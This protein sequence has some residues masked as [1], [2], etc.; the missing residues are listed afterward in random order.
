M[1]PRVAPIDHC[2]HSPATPTVD[3]FPPRELHRYALGT[4]AE[5]AASPSSRGESDD[6]GRQLQRCFPELPRMKLLGRSE[7]WWQISE[8]SM[9]TLW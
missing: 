8:I 6:L 4:S 9:D 5:V 3:S 2:H 7:A 1:G